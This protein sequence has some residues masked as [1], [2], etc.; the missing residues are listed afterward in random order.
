MYIRT[1][2]VKSIQ[3]KYQA[4]G[5]FYHIRAL[6]EQPKFQNGA[7]VHWS[8]IDSWSISKYENNPIHTYT[9]CITLNLF[10]SINSVTDFLKSI[11]FNH[12][13]IET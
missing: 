5:A 3:C 4:K 2:N 10:M 9:Q 6:I 8:E 12:D 1:V 11:Y 13:F 7:K